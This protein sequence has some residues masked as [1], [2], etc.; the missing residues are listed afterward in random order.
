M[1]WNGRRS[2]FLLGAVSKSSSEQRFSFEG[3]RRLPSQ[4]EVD[5]L[6][7]RVS[8]LAVTLRAKAPNVSETKESWIAHRVSPLHLAPRRWRAVLP[9][10]ASKA[11]EL[12]AVQWW[13]SFTATKLKDSF[14]DIYSQSV[15]CIC[16]ACAITIELRMFVLFCIFSRT[17]EVHCLHNSHGHQES[18]VTFNEGGKVGRSNATLHQIF[19]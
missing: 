14:L 7:P 15:T 5:W 13:L 3:T 19:F 4:F 6:T 1:T 10:P 12:S 16:T 9:F 2:F 8:D 11:W 17:L 18:N